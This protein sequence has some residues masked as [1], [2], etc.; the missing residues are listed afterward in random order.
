MTFYNAGFFHNLPEAIRS[1]SF[2]RLLIAG[3]CILGVSLLLWVRN[4]LGANNGWV[5]PSRHSSG[6]RPTMDD[7][8]VV[9]R[10]GATEALDKVPVHFDTTLS[11]VPHYL[12]VS[13]MEEDIAGH[14]LYDVLADVDDEIKKTHPDF[15]IYNRLQA[16][17]RAA[18][19]DKE[20]AS[21]PGREK[22]NTGNMDNPGWRLDKWKFLPM[23]DKAL[24]HQP[25]ARWF[26][27]MEADTY[28]SWP[29]LLHWLEYYDPSEPIC[30][31]RTLMAGSISFSHGGSGVIMSA[32]AMRR[33]SQMHA[34]RRQELDRYTAEEAWAGDVTVGKVLA[35][36]DV[37]LFNGQVNLLGERPSEINYAGEHSGKPIWCYHAVSFHHLRP[38]DVRKL[39]HVEEDLVHQVSCLLLLRPPRFPRSLFG[40]G[41]PLPTLRRRLQHSN[42]PSAAASS[43][44]M[45]QSLGRP[46]SRGVRQRRRLV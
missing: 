25:S 16:Q 17:G 14:H 30:I 31:G 42:I 12:L 3:L 39:W 10:T 35:E 6:H 18:F 9:F 8:L 24:E 32:P 21:W 36:A 26:V 22:G 15:A 34:D 28:I 45:G 19:S 44:G 1:K 38:E 41:Y 4:G 27:F 46:V 29:N 20:I 5:V 2:S 11:R 23:I 43:G 37:L 33:I 7:V 40:Q 13:D